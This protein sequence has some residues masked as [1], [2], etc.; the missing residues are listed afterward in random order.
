MIVEHRIY[1]THPGQVHEYLALY[2]AEGLAIQKRILGR[3]VGYYRSEI[4]G[5]NQVIH[6]WAY[7]DLAERDQRRAA[8]LADEGFR[9]YVRKITP[10]LAGQESRILVPAPFF[11]PTW[12]D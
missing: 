6:L 5:L 3:M 11:T 1:T 12:Q 8:L 4:G 2:E 7:A 10:L 9:H